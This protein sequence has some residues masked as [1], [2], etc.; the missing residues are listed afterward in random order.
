MATAE[1]PKI[2][3]VED[4][5]VLAEG[6]SEALRFQGY[7]VDVAADGEAGLALATKHAYDVMLLD[8]MMPKL[9][10]FEVMRRLREAGRTVPTIMLTAKGDE[11]DRIRG[12]EIGADDYVTKPFALKELVARVGAQIR[13][14]QR[15][16]GDGQVFELDGVTFD[17]GRLLAHRGEREIPL[18]PREG[19]ILT[20][21]R[22]KQG[23]VVTRDEFLL[24]V[25]RYPTSNVETRT[26]DNTLAALRRK[27]ER[28]PAAPR[29][30]LTVRGK[31]Y[32]WGG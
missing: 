19:E 16:R 32:R 4:E 2:L 10:G 7:D 23:N 21:L 9:D 26:V 14:T 12:I 28:D 29:I 15:E 13:R 18:T 25:W 11:E 6:L 17:L 5:D 22:S 24:H 30:I 27:I 1:R 3:I 31:G 8:I 20:H